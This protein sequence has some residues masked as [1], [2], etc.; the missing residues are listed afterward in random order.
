MRDWKKVARDLDALVFDLEAKGDYLPVIWWDKSRVNYDQDTFGIKAYVGD[1]RQTGQTYDIITCLEAVV[2]GSMAGIDK[3]NQN[4]RNWVAMCQNYYGKANGENV[5]LNNIGGTTG[6]T[7]WYEL[8]PNL[9]F[10]QINSRYP[11]VGEM[12]QHRWLP[13]PIVGATPVS[14]WAALPRRGSSL[15]S[16]IP[17]SRCPR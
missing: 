6:H 13:W 16:T 9:L 4:G 10:C 3:S 7:F 17:R 1:P 5:Y 8:L 12:D 15:I 14:P 11:G 2:A